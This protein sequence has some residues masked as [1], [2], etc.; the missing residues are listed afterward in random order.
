MNVDDKKEGVLKR[1]KNIEGKNEQQLE[2][3]RE[4]GGRYSTEGTK[5]IGFY[6]KENKKVADLVGRI[7]KIV[8]ENRNKNFVCTHSDA[9]QYDFN[10]YRDLNQFGSEIYNGRLTIK[11]AENE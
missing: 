10:Q 2:A 8:Q 7:N 11:D 5:R 6:D 4:E 3:I 1:L 9:T